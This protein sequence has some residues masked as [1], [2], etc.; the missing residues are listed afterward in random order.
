MDCSHCLTYMSLVRLTK[1]L[2]L[3]M[4]QVPANVIAAL[5]MEHPAFS[6]KFYPRS[7]R[8]LCLVQSRN[9][10]QIAPGPGQLPVPP[11]P[12]WENF[13]DNQEHYLASGKEHVDNMRRILGQQGFL[14]K[15]GQRI[16]ELGCA[17]GR[18]LRWLAAEASDGEAW[19]VDINA[20]YI[21]WCQQHLSP[22]FHFVTTTTLPHLPFP[23]HHF[24]LIYAGSVFTHISD[25]ADCWFL[26]LKRV[27]KPQGKLY[28]TI[29]D[30]HTIQLLREK[31]PDS[32]LAL[33]LFAYEKQV[34]PLGSDFGMCSVRRSPN[35]AQVFY[36]SEFLKHKLSPLFKVCSVT[37]E[38]Y[39]HQTGVLLENK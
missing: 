29:H 10:T 12:L 16:L 1:D 2:I 24:D 36:H 19:G 31:H 5:L 38:A 30:E 17:T 25:L 11:R 22:P 37:H 18:M 23:D 39:G 35:G 8:R 4:A 14:F 9:P 34:Q 3:Q 15:P 7:Q 6:A 28:V 13:A 26:E 33:I 27:L 20:E 32:P 21:S